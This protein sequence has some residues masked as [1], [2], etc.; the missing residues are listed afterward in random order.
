MGEFFKAVMHKEGYCMKIFSRDLIVQ[1]YYALDKKSCLE[2]M[3]E[4]L[5]KNN[6]INSAD[7]FLK[8]IMERENLMTTGIGR[9]VAIP[10]ARSSIVKEINIAVYVLDNELEFNSVDGEDV[11]VIFMIAVPED[12]K[13][14]YMKVLSG[15]SNFLRVDENRE[16]LF[17]AKTKDDIYE[18]L[19]G[20]KI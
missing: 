9:K 11:K 14:E 5:Y 20:I 2:E 12:K 18:M 17:N 3:V 8:A 6:V 13:D 7:D 16:K 1:N 10:H 15:I 4:F 19:K